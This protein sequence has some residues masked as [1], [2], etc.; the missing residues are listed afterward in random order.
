MFAQ[1]KCEGFH[2]S[3]TQ[4]VIACTRRDAEPRGVHRQH[5][6]P[7]DVGPDVTDGHCG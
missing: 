2:D 3:A 4:G 6:L 7:P 5:A 1:V